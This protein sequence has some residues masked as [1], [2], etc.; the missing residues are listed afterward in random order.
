MRALMGFGLGRLR[1][2]PD[3]FWAM[4][5]PE[6]LASLPPPVR[7]DRLDRAGLEALLALHTPNGDRS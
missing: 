2:S 3:A 1:L 4:S 5:L 7:P 6:I